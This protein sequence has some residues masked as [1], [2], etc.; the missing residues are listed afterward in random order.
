[1]SDR[2]RPHG[3]LEQDD[4]QLDAM[5]ARVRDV[6]PAADDEAVRRYARE[7]AEADAVLQQLA[8]DPSSIPLDVAFS[9]YWNDGCTP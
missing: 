3:S 5:L 2:N 8:L 6:D 1:M 4:H 7:I 9:P